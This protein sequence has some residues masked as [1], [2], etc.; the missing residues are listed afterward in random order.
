MR[1]W[2]KW[3]VASFVL[4]VGSAVLLVTVLPGQ[5]QDTS[6]STF[7]RRAEPRAA[8][9]GP[10]MGMG[11]GVGSGSMSSSGPAAAPGQGDYPM[12]GGTPL[13]MP[14][15]MPPGMY[16]G[17]MS[18]PMMGNGSDPLAQEMLVAQWQVD[19]AL[20]RYQQTEDETERQ[21]IKADLTTAL[22]RQ[23]EVQQQRRTNELA[24]I[25]N[26]VQKLRELIE[27]RNQAQQT[28]ISKRCDQLLSEL[29]GLGW[30]SPGEAL[31]RLAA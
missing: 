7:K 21:A 17:M 6:G 11:M 28:I 8:G 2:K 31:H 20:A 19:Q 27:K 14:G 9:A 1:S 4:W 26:R 24:E 13:G 10:G 22:Q 29:D 25:E 30:T 3:C 12:P 15:G 16:P 23:F 18:G 5:D